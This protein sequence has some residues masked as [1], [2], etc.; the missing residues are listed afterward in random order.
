[1]LN[2]IR[3]NSFNKINDTL[4]T[5]I[6]S[7]EN[8]EFIYD[9][10]YEFE[11]QYIYNTSSFKWR[12]LKDIEPINF[13]NILETITIVF[14]KSNSSVFYS[15]YIVYDKNDFDTYSEQNE[16]LSKI[17]INKY[18][19]KFDR[20]NRKTEINRNLIFELDV[21]VNDNNVLKPALQKLEEIKDIDELDYT[22]LLNAL[23]RDLRTFIL[24]YGQNTLNQF[25]ILFV[26]P[27]NIIL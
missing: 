21:Y 13:R 15:S 6:S 11:L 23:K 9:S 10:L 24:Y 27:D 3:L 18:L 1:M 2:G 7:S 20:Y 17:L 8:L 26:E 25:W 19:D 4:K 12:N 16:L 5:N 22:N 14:E